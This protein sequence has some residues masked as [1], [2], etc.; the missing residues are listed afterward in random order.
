MCK[1]FVKHMLQILSTR[2]TVS[3]IFVLD[4]SCGKGRHS[5]TPYEA[6]ALPK[7]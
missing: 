6:F 5:P 2:A 3:I 4:S 1:L 7:E